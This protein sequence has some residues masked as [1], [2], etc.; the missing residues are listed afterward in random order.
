[1]DI[2]RIELSKEKSYGKKDSC[3]Y[4]I[5]YLCKVTGPPLPLCVKLPKT[6]AYAKYFDKNNNCINLL[7]KDE[8]ILKKCS[9][10]WN[11]LVVY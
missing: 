11:K 3:K 4:F 10:I 7:V 9:A 2:K 5:R 1:M 6:N 8:E